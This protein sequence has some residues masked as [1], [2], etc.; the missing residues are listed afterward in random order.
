MLNPTKLIPQIW[1]ENLERVNKFRENVSGD[2]IL[3]VSDDQRDILE[4]LAEVARL[5]N[6]RNSN[7]EWK[8]TLPYILTVGY[9][10]STQTRGIYDQLREAVEY[11]ET[12]F[13]AGS[14]EQTK[15]VERSLRT[16]FQEAGLLDKIVLAD[17]LAAPRPGTRIY[18][19][20]DLRMEGDTPGKDMIGT[21]EKAVAERPGFYPNVIFIWSTLSAGRA[22]FAR[23][24][25]TVETAEH[26]N[27]I[28]VPKRAVEG[29]YGLGLLEDLTKALTGDSNFPVVNAKTYR[30]QKVHGLHY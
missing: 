17:N 23:Q 25:P 2:I 13:D 3:C 20:Q 28:A 1:G 4:G 19:V 11:N 29:S 26:I 8:G 12:H 18:H 24:I 27:I 22:A 5:Y 16:Q 9:S 14:Y 6:G 15:M 30:G 7:S 21:F 10:D